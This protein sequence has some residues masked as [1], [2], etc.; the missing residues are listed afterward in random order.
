VLL[1]ALVAGCPGFG[2]QVAQGL[3]GEA[4]DFPTYDG[5]VKL[6]LDAYCISCHTSPA[7]GGAPGY[8]RLD[9]FDTSGG[10]SGAHDMAERIVARTT[11]GTMPLGG[12]VLADAEIETLTKWLANGAPRD[13]TDL[14]GETGVTGETGE[15]GEPATSGIGYDPEV[16]SIL[17]E[18]CVACHVSPPNEGA[19]EYF[20]LDRYA[21]ED[22]IAGAYDQA[23]RIVARTSAGTMPQGGPAL[24]DED[25]A[26]LTAWYDDGA[27]EYGE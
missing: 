26:T 16:K 22:D 13:A 8:F 27:P 2:T 24:S 17:D 20:R 3:I 9:V 19:P 4:A 14:G 18:Y 23:A 1:A 15:T 5:D 25:V 11:A 6:I 10:V 12:P 21:T 7:A